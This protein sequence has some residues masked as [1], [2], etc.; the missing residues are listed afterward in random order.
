[1]ERRVAGGCWARPPLRAR[2]RGVRIAWTI[3]A[4]RGWG[5]VSAMVRLG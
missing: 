3:T 1:V 4:S 2:Q 5:D